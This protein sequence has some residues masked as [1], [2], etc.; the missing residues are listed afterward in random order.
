V[1]PEIR[2]T[3]ISGKG[4]DLVYEGRRGMVMEDRK[5]EWHGNDEIVDRR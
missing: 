3:E 5:R 4:R 1:D 2:T